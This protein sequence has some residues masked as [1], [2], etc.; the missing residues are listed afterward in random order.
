MKLIKQLYKEC[1]KTVSSLAQNVME[2]LTFVQ[3]ATEIL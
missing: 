3:H 2:K 1:V